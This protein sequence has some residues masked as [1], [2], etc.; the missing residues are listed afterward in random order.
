MHT[1]EKEQ[2][3][4]LKPNFSFAGI[5]VFNAMKVACDQ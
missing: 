1:F 3:K 4:E 5:F 2:K